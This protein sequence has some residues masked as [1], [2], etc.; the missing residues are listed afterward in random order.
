MIL[1]PY[2]PVR[3]SKI[4]KLVLSDHYHLTKNDECYFIGEY[5][6]RENFS[7]SATNQLITN[8]KKG[9]EKRGRLEWRYKGQAI[10]QIAREFAATLDSEWLQTVTLVPVPPPTM[11]NRPNG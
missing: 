3:L 11:R 1:Q 10:D 6:A 2:L 4:D 5:T 8:L 7:Y 9:L